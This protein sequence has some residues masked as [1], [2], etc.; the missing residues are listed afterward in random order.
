MTDAQVPTVTLEFSA[1]GKIFGAGDLAWDS[2][3]SY[4][5]TGVSIDA[6][7]IPTLEEWYRNPDGILRAH[8][9][10]SDTHTTD[11]IRC[12]NLVA[13]IGSLRNY[14]GSPPVVMALL[15]DDDADVNDSGFVANKR[16]YTWNSGYF[17]D[18]LFAELRG[19]N[20][21]KETISDW[22]GAPLFIQSLFD[23]S[24]NNV[25]SAT[26]V[27]SENLTGDAKDYV[28]SNF[29]TSSSPLI[30]EGSSRNSTLTDRPGKTVISLFESPIYPK[31]VACKLYVPGG[32]STIL[33]LP[34]KSVA[35]PKSVLRTMMLALATAALVER[36]RTLPLIVLG[37]IWEKAVTADN[38]TAIRHIDFRLLIMEVGMK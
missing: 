26:W 36:S 38:R 25:G 16:L 6:D 34:S 7:S 37:L 31:A 18:N 15:R 2:D 5:K 29:D 4:W 30:A 24:S 21:N 35:A 27:N 8:A 10:Y 23:T 20:V 22:F 1:N 28:Q 32:I 3:S 14:N 11:E 13:N 12:F 33:K 17:E 9:N 19:T